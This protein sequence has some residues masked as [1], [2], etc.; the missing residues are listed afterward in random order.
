MADFGKEYL[1]SCRKA[2]RLLRMPWQ[3]A[4]SG[5]AVS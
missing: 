3:D 1:Q 4:A 2:L 5:Q